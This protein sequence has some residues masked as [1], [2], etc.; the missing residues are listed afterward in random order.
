[1]GEKMN[2][3][4]DVLRKCQA[5]TM[6]RKCLLPLDKVS[7]LYVLSDTKSFCLI[8]FL[9]LDRRPYLVCLHMPV[10]VGFLISTIRA[11][12]CR[13]GFPQERL[14]RWDFSIFLWEAVYGQYGQGNGF[15][16]VCN[17]RCS[18]RSSLRVVLYEQ[19]VQEWGFSPVCFRICLRS[20]KELG[21]L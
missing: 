19:Y 1:M 5:T 4:S 9:V 2:P 7:L 14:R 8:I 6:T 16:P 21:T 11:L 17:R 13:H 10:Q 12:Y 20:L 18:L 3:P 15:S